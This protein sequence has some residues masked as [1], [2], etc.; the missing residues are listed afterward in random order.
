MENA[1]RFKASAEDDS[2]Y[3]PDEEDVPPLMT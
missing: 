1:K 2:A 3:D